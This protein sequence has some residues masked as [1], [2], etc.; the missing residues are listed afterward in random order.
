VKAVN[1]E[2]NLDLPLAAVALDRDAL[3][4]TKP[5]FLDE[6]WSNDDVQ[7]VVLYQQTTLVTSDSGLKLFRPSQLAGVAPTAYLGKSLEVG[8]Q[9]V[10]AVLNE[11]SAKAL[12][13]DE[14]EWHQLRKTGLGL[15]AADA[16]IFAQ[17]LALAN[18]HET[19]GFCPT[20]GSAT[21]V[22]SA[23]WVR[24]CLAEGREL[25]PRTDPAVIVGILDDQD[26]ILLGS[27]GAWE[28]NRFSILA[29]FVEPGESLEAAVV[30]EM[31]EEAGIIV[32]DPKFVGSQ[33]W[34][35][36]YSL[37]FGFTARYVSGDVVPDGEEI[38]K[39]RWFS[40]DEL[41]SEAQTLLLPGRMS[42]ARAIIEHW[43]GQS[44]KDSN[45]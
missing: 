9:Y 31:N 16:S 40:R 24:R 21:E 27:Q 33:A 30:R 34:P 26:R 45:D 42:I 43:L 14:L 20:C 23:G 25:F 8:R 36:P 35:Y 22:T 7:V 44:V 28:S 19:H 39:L 3:S 1:H 32:A 41:L 29:G 11:H 38:V 13:P 17:G 6:L 18:W 5:N 37:M 4:R 10:L 15:S 2:V 12:E